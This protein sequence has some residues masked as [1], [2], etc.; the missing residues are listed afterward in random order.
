MFTAWMREA[1][2]WLRAGLRGFATVA[3]IEAVVQESF[4]RVWS[5]RGA[6][7]AHPE[8]RSLYRLVA[9]IARRLA[10]DEARRSGRTLP[11]ESAPEPAAADASAPDPMLRRQIQRCRQ[12]L[13]GKPLLALEARLGGGGARRDRELAEGVGMRENTFLQNLSRARKQLLHCLR[14]AGVV[15]EEV[16][17]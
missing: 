2:P 12:G 8:G 5:G 10:L 16:M 17:P 9:T 6:L 3:D 13:S 7:Q 4:L 15:L 1:E 14:K 11:F